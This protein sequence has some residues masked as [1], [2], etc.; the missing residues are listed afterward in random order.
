M[1]RTINVHFFATIRDLDFS[2]TIE[3]L[4]DNDYQD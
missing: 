3:S 4:F 2:K 1:N